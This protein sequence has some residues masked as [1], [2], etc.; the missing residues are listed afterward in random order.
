[1]NCLICH[2][3]CNYDGIQVA[4]NEVIPFFKIDLLKLKYPNHPFPRRF[5][6]LS[7]S[8]FAFSQ[9]LAHVR[10][11]NIT[12]RYHTD[13]KWFNQYKDQ[14]LIKFGIE[15]KFAKEAPENALEVCEFD[16][17]IP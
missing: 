4:E 1:M 15:I 9:I 5:K 12:A 8:C 11:K 3:G 14:L 2:G 6:N 7:A 13:N 10:G 16:L 17:G